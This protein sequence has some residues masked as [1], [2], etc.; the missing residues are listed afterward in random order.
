MSYYG[1][2][3]VVE[4]DARMKASDVRKATRLLEKH[5]LRP[6][7]CFLDEMQSDADDAAD[8]GH[9]ARMIAIPEDRCW[10]H[11]NH[12]NEESLLL[13]AGLV[14]GR[15]SAVSRAKTAAC[16]AGSSSR[17]ACWRSAT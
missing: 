1:K 13:V 3:Q 8:A 17:S 16:T 10:F 14:K 5:D 7:S 12:V 15:L 9:P 2:L 4:C 6:E 11:G